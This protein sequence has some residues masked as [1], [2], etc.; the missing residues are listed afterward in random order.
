MTRPL[1][2]NYNELF[3]HLSELMSAKYIDKFRF[4]V[5]ILVNK[6]ILL[7]KTINNLDI[8]KV[9]VKRPCHRNDVVFSFEL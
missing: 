6:R 4:I 3:N 8:S 5:S 9:I 7:N 1:H 2:L